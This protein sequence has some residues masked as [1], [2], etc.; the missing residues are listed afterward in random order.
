MCCGHYPLPPC[1]SSSGDGVT[2]QRL[3]F[4]L[5]GNPVSSLVTFHLFVA[6]ALRCLRGVPVPQ[7]V[8]AR[9][10]VTVTSRLPLDPERPEFHRVIVYRD[11][12]GSGGS[13]L[14]AVSTGLQRSS[15]LTSMR[16]AN[17]M[18]CLPRAEGALDAGTV[19]DWCCVSWRGTGVV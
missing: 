5:P 6:P 11:A 3:A 13:G 12:G 9:V 10:P 16:T 17:G 15:R 7:C 19:L 1:Q 4:G 2:K 14:A 8:P 18:L